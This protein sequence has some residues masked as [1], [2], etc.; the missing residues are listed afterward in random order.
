MTRSIKKLSNDVLQTWKIIQEFFRIKKAK[1]CNVGKNEIA[2][3]GVKTKVVYIVSYDN[4]KQVEI[5]FLKM[6][7]SLGIAFSSV[8]KIP[9]RCEFRY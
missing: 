4:R 5:F 3:G 9:T 2:D 6:R 7:F 1:S 8:R